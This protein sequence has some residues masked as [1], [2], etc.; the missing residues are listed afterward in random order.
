VVV[1]SNPTADAG[2]DTTIANGTSATLTGSATGGTGSYNYSWTP[3]GL[4]ISSNIA[5]PQTVNLT[6]STVFTLTVTDASTGCSSTSQVTVIISGGPL[7]A[8]ASALGAGACVG[9]SIAIGV[10]ASGGLSPYTYSWTS[11][12]TGFTSNAMNPIV[13]PTVNTTY[14]VSVWDGFNTVIDSV[15]VAAYS[16]PVATASNTGPYC[17]GETIQL[18]SSG[19]TGYLWAGPNSYG[20][21]TEDPSISPALVG[22]SGN[23]TVTVS[24]GNGCSSTATTTVTVNPLPSATASNGGPYCEGDNIQLSSGGGLSYSWEGPASYANP[25]QNPSISNATPAIA[26]NYSVTVT[27]AGG[28]TSYATTSV[29]VNELP[30]ITASSNSPY[31]VG[32]SIVLLAGGGSDY[33]WSG[34]GS[35]SSNSQSPIIAPALI[36]QSGTYYVTATDVNGCSNTAQTTIIVNAS[37][38]VYISGAD[39]ICEGETITLTATGASNYEWNTG[40]LSSTISTTAISSATYIVTGSIGSCTDI[41]SISVVVNPSPVAD[42]GPDTTISP[43]DAI[44]LN[45]SGG[46]SYLWIPSDYLSDANISNPIC[47]PE[48]SITYILLVTNEFGCTSTDTVLVR[49]DIECGSIYVPNAFSPNNDGKNDVFGVFNRCLTVIDLKVFNQW[50]NLVFETTDPTTRWDGTFSGHD[51][52]SGIYSFYYKGTL[53]DETPVEGKGNFVLIR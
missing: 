3:S 20:T 46:L 29:V 25:T 32:D 1:N 21:A 16:L 9:D 28:C 43:G 4:L 47:T 6:T 34:P 27:G 30:T 14:I 31:C 39:T 38:N 52:E 17:P 48:D 45:G 7:T 44:Q 18:N 35:F 22:N 42:A 23:Y 19:G 13:Y 53:S 24:N 41:D 26:G 2:N 50:G 15:A 40:S 8:D 49:L 11:N 33:V 51:A 12:P 36:A 10:L 37:P 5:N